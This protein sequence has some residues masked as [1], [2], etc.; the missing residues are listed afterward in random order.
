VASASPGLIADPTARWRQRPADD[1]GPAPAPAAYYED[2]PAVVAPAPAVVAPAP[3]AVYVAPAYGYSYAEP[4]V[5]VDP[6]TGRWCR[7][8]AS[9]YHWC[10]TP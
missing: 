6:V 2:E 9:G 7:I 5:V 10:W 3:A 4:Y 8:E 1:Y